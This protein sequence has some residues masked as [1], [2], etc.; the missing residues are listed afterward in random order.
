VGFAELV[1]QCKNLVGF[2]LVLELDQV[3]KQLVNDFL[4]EGA[5][6]DSGGRKEEVDLFP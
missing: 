1:A 6:A 2:T 3:R 5:L 4:K